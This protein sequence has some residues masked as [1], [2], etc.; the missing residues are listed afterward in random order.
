ML[1][2]ALVLGAGIGVQSGAPL[3]GSGFVASALSLRS[4]ALRHQVGRVVAGPPSA[5]GLVS[6]RSPIREPYPYLS[7]GSFGGPAVPESPDPLVRYRWAK[8]GPAD[9]LQVYILAPKSITGTPRA[10]FEGLT[11]GGGGALP[12]RDWPNQVSEAL[13]HRT[14]TTERRPT[15]PDPAAEVWGDNAITVR[16][17]GDI[18]IDFGV[19]SAAWVEFDSP[20]CPGGVEMSISEYNQ[21]WPGKTGT[22]V[23]H[24]NT[25]RLEL[26][27][28][29]YE[30][31]RFAWIHVK[32]LARPWHITGIRAV[33]QV[34]P[35]NYLGSFSCSDPVITRS[36]YMS[37]YGVKLNYTKDY[38]GAILM[39][40]GDRISWTGDAHPSQAAALV[41]FGDYG[42]I[43]QNL[44]STA[45]QDNGI[46]SYA[47]YW[48]LSLLD[49]YRYTGDSATLEKFLPNACKK[50]DSAYEAFG[51][52]PPLGF[53][54]WDERLCAG[55]ELW[56]LPCP[57]A[58]RA[59][60]ML[61]IRAWR[62]F[63]GVMAELGRVDLMD[64]YRGYA[65]FE[66]QGDYGSTRVV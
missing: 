7:G 45:A 38:I 53:Y 47:L 49:Y 20:D 9:G 34:K 29:L 30:G 24:G 40:R 37:A 18:R 28:Q 42:F 13:E 15:R 54:G 22:P 61:S 44:I 57:E 59:Y 12:Y 6:G 43:K 27:D 65:G 50:L 3:C 10:A 32:A 46:R 58:Q 62:E 19:E 56:T 1:V 23:K 26:N 66:V 2:A 63:A 21:P 5:T 39:D 31:V 60:Q 14:A 25:Y 52:N 8:T 48:V 64:R 4:V 11:A 51:T 33:C 16:G 36:W 17:K 55:F 41:A 35:T